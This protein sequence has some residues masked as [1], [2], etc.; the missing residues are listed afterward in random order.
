MPV[1]RALPT[2]YFVNGDTGLKQTTEANWE[3]KYLN[4]EEIA[5]IVPVPDAVHRR[6]RLRYLG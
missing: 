5:A 1:L 3:N 6:F 4:A 2:A